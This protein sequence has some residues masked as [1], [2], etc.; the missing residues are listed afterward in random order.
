MEKKKITLQDIAKALNITPSAVSK[1]LSNH[2]RMS[3]Q[4]KDAV[5][6]KANELNYKPN[7]IAAALRSGQSK[8]IGVIVPAANISFFSSVIR[9]I[10]ETA[11]KAGYSV[12]LTQSNDSVKK[13]KDIIN[14][15]LATRVDGVIA[16]LGLKTKKYDHFEKLKEEG[17]PLVFFD[18]ILKNFGVSTV[19]VDD[20]KGAY[21]AV[22]HLI[23]QGCKK[24]AHLAG[25]SH[26]ELYKNR[27]KGYKAALKDASM[28]ICK[29]LILESDLHLEDGRNGM[30]RLLKMKERPD[31]IFCSS[32]YSAVGALQVAREQ[33]IIVPDEITIFGFSNEPFTSYLDPGISSVDQSSI[34]MGHT[35]G[36]LILEQIKGS[37]SEFIPRSIVLN[38]SLILRKSSKK[39]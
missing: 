23:D 19:E 12:I 6:K 17:V 37:K 38:P 30:L 2:P 27:L 36:E 32:D 25:H 18:R 29:E 11:N 39:F 7:Q 26:M 5:N 28:P 16:A 35:A 4:T 10:E 20:Y 22:H 34:V 24:I 1:A 31:A 8:L 15:L 3:Q 33:N 14:T 13:E 9:G 21:D